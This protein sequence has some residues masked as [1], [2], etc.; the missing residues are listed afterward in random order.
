MHLVKEVLTEMENLNLILMLKEA[1]LWPKEI[2]VLLLVIVFKMIVTF[3]VTIGQRKKTKMV[4]IKLKEKDLK[5]K[6]NHK[7]KLKELPWEK[8]KLLLKPII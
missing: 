7:L 3:G 1:K 6:I 5:K 2:K 8:V 4:N